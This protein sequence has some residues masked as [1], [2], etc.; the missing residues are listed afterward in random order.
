MSCTVLVYGV[1]KG[2]GP[3]PA[4]TSV[5]HAP[6]I[7]IK[8]R[9]S[10]AFSPFLR[11]GAPKLQSSAERTPQRPS[12][13]SHASG[14]GGWVPKP[15]GGVT[16]PSVFL[17][18]STPFLWAR[19]KKWGGIC[20]TRQNQPTAK[21]RVP[22]SQT[23]PPGG[24]GTPPLRGGRRSVVGLAVD[25]GKGRRGRRPLRVPAERAACHGISRAPDAA[26]EMVK[27]PPERAAF[28][29]FHLKYT[30]PEPLF[31][32]YPSVQASAPQSGQVFPAARSS[33]M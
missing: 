11:R 30:N 29:T 16:T 1:A 31:S 33:S 22:P 19:P 17:W 3:I 25:E 32:G 27:T 9:P 2:R 14:R 5:Y 13:S 10:G 4:R 24:D 21:R 6:H 7:E 23:P 26:W 15:H 18:G 8:K 12:G 20:S 28:S